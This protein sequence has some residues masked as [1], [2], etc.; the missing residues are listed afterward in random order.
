MIERHMDACLVY[1]FETVRR[2]ILVFGLWNVQNIR[3]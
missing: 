3:S 1:V 2:D